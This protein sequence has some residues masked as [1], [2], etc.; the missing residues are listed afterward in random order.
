MDRLV[1][2][3]GNMIGSVFRRLGVPTNWMLML[4]QYKEI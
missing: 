4:H 3:V 1:G 2:A